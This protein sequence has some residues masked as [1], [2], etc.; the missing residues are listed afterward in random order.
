MADEIVRSP[1]GVKRAGS[2]G[3]EAEPRLALTTPVEKTDR[4]G[5]EFPAETPEVIPTEAVLVPAV[6]NAFHVTAEDEQKG[7]E[8][9]ELVDPPPLLDAHP[10]LEALR[11]AALAPAP[12]V[13]DHDAGV[14]VAGAAAPER[15]REGRGGPEPGGEVGGEVGVA[16]LGGAED[17]GVEGDGPEL[18]DVVDEDEVGVEVDDAA[19]GGGEEHGGVDAGVVE[20][21]LEGAPD[22]G[23][24]HA[25]HGVGVEEVD[26]ESQVREGGG[27]RP[28]EGLGAAP[29]VRDEVEH[30]ALRAGR[31]LEDR[32]DAGHGAAEVCRS[33]VIAMWIV[34]VEFSGDRHSGALRNAGASR[35]SGREAAERENRRK[36]RER[37]G[38]MIAG[39]LNGRE[40]KRERWEY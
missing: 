7:W 14:E 21:L 38:G 4:T 29:A 20:G 1:E 16:V 35:N 5:V 28:A 6:L 34:A 39:G 33:S 37:N 8:R 17:A 30:D 26:S 36:R 27:D 12:E 22:R 10:V 25:P 32:Q 15:R 23:G 11:V 31:V 24:D 19:D 2:A 9:A 40:R 13:D 3:I 18:G